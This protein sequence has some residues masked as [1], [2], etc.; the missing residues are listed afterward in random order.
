V[1]PDH[2]DSLPKY[3]DKFTFARET[4]GLFE[5]GN[6]RDQTSESTY[7]LGS[8]FID[9]LERG[10]A[11][12]SLGSAASLDRMMRDTE[13]TVKG[14]QDQGEMRSLALRGVLSHARL[15]ELDL[16][17]KFEKYQGAYEA[18]DRDW[19]VSLM[20][21]WH[22]TYETTTDRLE[23]FDRYGFRNLETTSGHLLNGSG[24]VS[25]ERSEQHSPLGSLPLLS[26]LELF[27]FNRVPQVTT[28]TVRHES[29]TDSFNGDLANKAIARMQNAGD[30]I[31]RYKSNE[32][33]IYQP[34]NPRPPPAL[35]GAL[36]S[37]FRDTPAVLPGDDSHPKSPPVPDPVSQKAR[38]SR[39]NNIPPSNLHPAANTDRGGIYADIPISSADFTAKKGKKQ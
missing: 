32:F 15:P 1:S 31:D 5:S 16:S 9:L 35:T 23:I 21:A 22:A 14:F 39:R 38:S 12:E 36:P 19:R 6:D 28:I 2:L 25:R 29:Y 30:G 17:Q 13:S 7:E 4:W 34:F 18:H 26:G 27:D 33:L 37:R 10:G 11:Y 3:W 20:G 24:T 8:Y